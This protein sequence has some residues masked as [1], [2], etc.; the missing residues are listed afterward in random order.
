MRTVFLFLVAS[1]L[2]Q[3]AEGQ[4]RGLMDSWNTDWQ[5]TTIALSELSVN[6]PRDAIPALDQPVFVDQSQAAV[7]LAPQEPV[8]VLTLGGA[9]RAYP[10]QILIWHEIVND[11]FGVIPVAVTFCPL[12][13][14]AIA[15]DR[16]INGAELSF[17][18][19]GML[20]LSDLVMFDRATQSLWQQLSGE[21][22]VGEYAGELLKKLPAQILSFDQLRR[23]YPDAPVLGRDTGHGRPYGSNPYEGY[24][25]ID[26]RPWMYSGPVD[27]RLRPMEKVVAVEVG[28]ARRAYPH[29]LTRQ[30]GVVH[31][32]LGDRRIVV[33]HDPDGAASAMDAALIADSR[34]LGE[35]GVFLPQV[36]GRELTFVLGDQGFQDRETG[37]LWSVTGRAKSGPLQG[38]QLEAVVHGDFFAFAWLAAFPDS[39]VYR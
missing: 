23:S 11:Q 31:D 17:G 39:D 12:C 21:A 32:E 8:V 38:R 9:T 30:Q 36:D 16:R 24:D 3:L 2:A 26:E 19:S 29:T 5:A 33:L 14:S 7:W 15:F 25:D 28:D 1:L 10:L 34:D 4:P 37:S 27:G 20:R 22:I 18:V 35:T 13:Y 6:V